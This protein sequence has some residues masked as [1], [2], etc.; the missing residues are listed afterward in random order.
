[1]NDKP[2]NFWKRLSIFGVILVLTLWG[3]DRMLYRARLDEEKNQSVLKALERNKILADELSVLFRGVQDDFH[4]FEKEILELVNLDSKS[5]RYQIVIQSLMKFLETHSGYFMVRLTNSSGKELFKII[6]TNKIFKQ[7]VDLFDLSSQP[8]YKDLNSVK[9]NS[10]FISAL[11][12]LVINGEVIKPI[13]PTIRISKRI[14]LKNNEEG[15]LI[16]N[17]DG[18]RILNLFLQNESRNNVFKDQKYL[19]D[20][21][22]N[23]ML[24]YPSIPGRQEKNRLPL[25]FKTIENLKIKGDFQG[26]VNIMRGL[27]VYTKILLPNT[28]ENWFLASKIDQDKWQNIVQKKRLTWIFWGLLSFFILMLW[29]WRHEKKRFKDEVVEVLLQERNEFIQNVSHQLKTPL[30]ILFNDLNKQDPTGFDWS[31]IKKEVTHL[32]KVVDDMLL[33]AMVDANPDIPLEAQD[34]LELISDSIVMVG[35]KAK[36]KNVSIRLNVDEKLYH[37]PHSLEK[38]V[39]GDLIK[40]AIMNILDNAIDFSPRDE[41]VEIF[42]STYGSKIKIKIKDNG[43]GISEH[44]LPKLFTRFTR[45]TTPGRKGSGLGLSI[46]KKIVELH[47][48]EIMVLEHRNGTVLEITL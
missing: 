6:E 11:E 19:L 37:L 25:S 43:P 42:I 4:Y 5:P 36:D 13:R 9:G 17:I 34:L 47:G 7:S 48:G 2:K 41:I 38:P 33:L 18:D 40:S 24:S 35:P 23:Y 39:M 46:A 8:F 44:I 28:N 12:P 32:T 26:F 16:F 27:V 20:S 30:A 45:G 10:F 1:M 21:S 29:F 22:G 15:L 14:Y 3:L 31:E